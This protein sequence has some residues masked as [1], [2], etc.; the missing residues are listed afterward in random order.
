MTPEVAVEP[1]AP[2]SQPLAVAS[3]KPGIIGTSAAEQAQKAVA[4]AKAKANAKTAELN[5]AFAEFNG[6]PDKSRAHPTSANE[7]RP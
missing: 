6:I 4:A 3:P 7:L 2:R 1:S 5:R